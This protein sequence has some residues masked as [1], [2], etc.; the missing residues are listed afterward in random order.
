MALTWGSP[1]SLAGESV[2]KIR[3]ND[4]SSGDFFGLAAAVSGNRVLI[5]A[6]YD[7]GS[8]GGE[9]GAAYLY[10]ALTGNQLFKL[11]PPH[12][13]T[14]HVMGSAV[15]MDGTTLLLGAPYKDEIGVAG[16][17]YTFDANTGALL[18]QFGVAGLEQGDHFGASVGVDGAL[19][20]VGAYGDDDS[21]SNAGAA[22]I[23]NPFTAQQLHKLLASDGAAGDGFGISSAIDGNR[24]LVGAPS[25]TGLN[26]SGAAYIFDATT[27]L[28]LLK[29]VPLDGS[30]NDRFGTAVS[31]DGN[32]AIVGALYHDDNG[33]ASGAAY[34]FD[35]TTGQ[36]L[37]KLLPTDGVSDDLFGI[38]VDVSGNRAIV[39][40]ERHTGSAIESG[41]AYLFD[42]T[43]GQQVLKLMAPDSAHFDRLGS[44]V[45]IEGTLAV[46]GAIGDDP[47]V[48]FGADA[49]SAYILDLNP[50]TW[51]DMGGAM[52]GSNGTPVLVASGDL[53]DNS[54]VSLVLSLAAANANTTLVLGY[55]NL[56]TPF[57]GGTLVPVPN[58][59]VPG[60]LTDGA[61]GLTI[62]ATW[63]AGLPGSTH[64]FLQLW[65]VDAAG[66]LGFVGSNGVRGFTP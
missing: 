26:D 43:T 28:E 1:A 19:A 40:A 41:A 59:L 60:L 2:I 10:D 39:G 21:G 15:A 6:P 51:V 36:Q 30:A 56:S 20:V 18:W 17:C 14:G 9:I 62:N 54:P 45:A 61:G 63:P 46:A 31:I 13:A 49:G 32:V 42:V 34:L 64:F 53:T 48:G 25:A 35:V 52:L 37:H 44:A 33:P 3:A 66:P 16:S 8:S 5:G 57:K 55:A 58:V 22:Y 47:D 38:S 24:I 4:A 23:M 29:L 65:M 50:P 11:S 12:F 27:G 7:D